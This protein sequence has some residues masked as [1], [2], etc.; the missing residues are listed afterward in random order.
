MMEFFVIAFAVMFAW[1]MINIIEV[2]IEAYRDG[3]RG[4]Y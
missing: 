1:G 4:G 3:G 2:L